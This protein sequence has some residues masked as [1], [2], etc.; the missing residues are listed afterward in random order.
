MSYLDG[1]KERKRQ[2]ERYRPHIEA[3]AKQ[4]ELKQPTIDV[5]PLIDI[6]KNAEVDDVKAALAKDMTNTSTL[7]LALKEF[8]KAIK[9]KRKTVGMH[10]DH[11]TTLMQAF[12]LLV[13]EWKELSANDTNYDKC[14]EFGA[15]LLVFCNL[16]DYPRWIESDLRAHLKIKY[17][18]CIINMMKP[19]R[20]LTRRAGY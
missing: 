8:R 7:C 5:K 15:K 18:H 6:L 9:P 13:S 17:V 14:R 4:I 3:L 20:S 16:K 2:Y 11:Y 19:T 10:Y 1:E 12:D